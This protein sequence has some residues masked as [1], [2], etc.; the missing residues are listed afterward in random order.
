MYPLIEQL[1]KLDEDSFPTDDYYLGY[2]SW[3]S[4]AYSSDKNVTFNVPKLAIE[5]VES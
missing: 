3:G 1:L 5:L 2:M 4:E